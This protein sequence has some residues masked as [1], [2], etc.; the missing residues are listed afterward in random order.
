MIE[1]SFDC[2]ECGDEILYEVEGYVLVY[3]GND[4][5]VEVTCEGCGEM[6]DAHLAYSY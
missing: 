3:S 5:D 6:F 1:F 2:P 4:L